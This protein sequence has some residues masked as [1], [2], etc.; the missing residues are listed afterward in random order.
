MRTGMPQIVEFF[1]NHLS[2][3]LTDYTGNCVALSSLRVAESVL[4]RSLVGFAI[5][6][7]PKSQYAPHIWHIS[8]QPT[9]HPC[10]PGAGSVCRDLGVFL[11]YG[12]RLFV[13]L[14]S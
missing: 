9:D 2:Q 5:R 13:L 12:F 1:I 11:F 3:Y 7:G 14:Y 6:R 10:H 4:G 8:L